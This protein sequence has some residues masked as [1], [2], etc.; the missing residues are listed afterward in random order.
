[1]ETWSVIPKNANCSPTHSPGLRR[2]SSIGERKFLNPLI[3]VRVINSYFTTPVTF[4]ISEVFSYHKW[5]CIGF[6]SCTLLS[7]NESRVSLKLTKGDLP[8]NCKQ[9][10]SCD[11]EGSD[12]IW[13]CFEADDSWGLA[14]I[15]VNQSSQ[16]V[17]GARASD[18]A[19]LKGMLCS[20]VLC[21]TYVW[22]SGSL[23]AKGI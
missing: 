23:L 18:G 21:E 14:Q 22:W 6:M 11:F 19:P 7:Q 4:Y 13:S 5:R 20:S 10:L 15:S 1:M 8:Q 16:K 3:Q 2:V 17:T 12:L 9:I